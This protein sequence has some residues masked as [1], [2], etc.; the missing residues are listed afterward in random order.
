MMSTNKLNS[1]VE[2]R[3]CLE[4]YRICLKLTAHSI[5]SYNEHIN[6]CSESYRNCIQN[7]LNY[8]NNSNNSK[9][10]KDELK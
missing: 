2:K 8:L 1:F 6:I 3:I 7:N 4:T 10:D 9:R 5:R